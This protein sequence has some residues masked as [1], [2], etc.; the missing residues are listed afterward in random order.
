MKKILATV[1]AL[2]MALSMTACG[3]SEPAAAPEEANETVSEEVTT[4]DTPET[5]DAAEE[6]A[7]EQEPEVPEEPAAPVIPD[8]YEEVVV[9]SEYYGVTVSFAG[10]ND[11]RFVDRDDKLNE[12]NL[13]LGRTDW[14]IKYVSDAEW[15][16][17]N[18][19]SYSISIVAT[20]NTNIERD[21]KNG[22]VIEDSEYTAFLTDEIEE[23][24]CKV[25]FYTEEGSYFN[26]RIRVEADIVAYKGFMT[27]EEFK[28]ACETFIDTIS[29]TILD[30]NNLNDAEGNF[31][32]CS[33]IYTVPASITI[34]GHEV[35]NHWTVMYG[36]TRA[37]GQ[38]TDDN[39]ELVT[40]F[41]DGKNIVKYVSSR[42]DDEEHYRH[43]Q[44]GD[45]Y[46]I[47]EM[48]TLEGN[49]C[50]EYT[51]VFE[52]DGDNETNMTFRIE[53]GHAGDM[54]YQELRDL[55]ADDAQVSELYQL[56]DG[57]AEEYLSQIVYHGT[58]A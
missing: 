6:T 39:G 45:Y 55:F 5:S 9:N 42:Y 56:L 30:D 24:K 34:A 40:V 47:C 28:T 33:G 18:Y 13:K 10:L 2:T 44:F 11:G 37:A 20:D 49:I 48:D 22:I 54:S 58:G 41:E 52:K 26:G 35:E 4:V 27:A 53:F 31:P 29:I 19:L 14:E 16:N 25:K 15:R 12:A 1:L 36:C 23:N 50:A 38:F 3:G 51:I 57:Y 32:T 7:E 8:G 17:S 43:I 21:M 46:G